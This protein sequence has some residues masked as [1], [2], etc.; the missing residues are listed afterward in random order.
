MEVNNTRLVGVQGGDKIVISNP[1]PVMTRHEAL[2]LAAFLVALSD[3][4][5]EFPEYLKAA[6]K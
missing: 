3:F 4:K 6:M 2:E 5:N 1:K